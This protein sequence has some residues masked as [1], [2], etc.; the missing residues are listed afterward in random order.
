MLKPLK[1]SKLVGAPAAEPGARDE[2]PNLS[3]PGGRE[4]WKCRSRWRECLILRGS[5]LTRG[6]E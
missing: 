2:V 4:H 1:H 5:I 3:G 6:E